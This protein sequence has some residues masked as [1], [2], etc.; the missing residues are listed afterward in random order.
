MIE[1]RVHGRGGQGAVTAS[2]L[3]ANSAFLEG[4]FSQAFPKF[5]PERSGAPVEAYAR[6]DDKFIGLRSR[7]YEPD[8]LI[9]LDSS[10]TNFLD[11][12]KKS[13]KNSEESSL[14][15]RMTS[16]E[17]IRRE[18]VIIINTNKTTDFNFRTFRIDATKIAVEILG[19]PIVNTVM[20]GAFAKATGLINMKSLEKAL[21]ERFPKELADKNWEAI[22]R[23]YEEC[24]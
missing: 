12:L 1:I 6:I 2:E 14:R 9:V 10:L 23:A 13:A 11:G 21:R 18:G 7:I 3:I 22:K 5:G 20:L 4:K 16:E 19:R 8:C 24:K 17:V 15:S